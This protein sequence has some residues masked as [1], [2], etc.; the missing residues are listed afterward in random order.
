MTPHRLADLLDSGLSARQI[1]YLAF[2]KWLLARGYVS[3]GQPGK[4]LPDLRPNTEP[5]ESATAHAWL[6]RL[7]PW[8]PPHG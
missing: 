7:R 5:E 3:E 1:Q 4:P 2:V 8:V 6:K